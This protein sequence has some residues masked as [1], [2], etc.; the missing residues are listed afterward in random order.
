M[1][2]LLLLVLLVE[3]LVVDRRD[4]GASTHRRDGGTSTHRRDGGAST[5]VSMQQQLMAMRDPL[6][7]L[8]LL[9]EVMA[10]FTILLKMERI[11]CKHHCPG[12]I[13]TDMCQYYMCRDIH[14]TLDLCL[15]L[16]NHLTSMAG[17]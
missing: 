14:R 1:V 10:S 16:L 7:Q 17:R 2:V 8:E 15:A 5:H 3:L 11:I 12:A 6:G 9:C 4:E 13:V